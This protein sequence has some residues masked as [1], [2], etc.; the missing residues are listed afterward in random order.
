MQGRVIWS[1]IGNGDADKNIVRTVFGILGLDV[2][3]PVFVKRAGILEF[4]FALE[5]ATLT[6]F[7]HQ[8]GIGIFRLRI[9]IE[10]FHVGMGRHGIEVET[11]S[12]PRG[13]SVELE[14]SDRNATFCM[15]GLI[16][17]F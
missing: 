14:V 11:R 7:P 12:Y 4:E 17:V 2:K 8:P 3:V 5:Q 1:A 16:F 9:L 15:K 6:I 13:E 10:R